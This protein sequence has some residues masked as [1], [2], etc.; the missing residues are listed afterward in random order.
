LSVYEK[1]VL[2]RGTGV[3]GP[4]ATMLIYLLIPAQMNIPKT[5]QNFTFMILLT[6]T[7]W[8]FYPILEF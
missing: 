3:D 2:V 6:H 8:Y 5:E 7:S 1:H 4:L